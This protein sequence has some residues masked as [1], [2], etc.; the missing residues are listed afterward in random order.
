MQDNKIETDRDTSPFQKSCSS[1][2]SQNEMNTSRTNFKEPL[3]NRNEQNE[4]EV[5]IMKKRLSEKQNNRCGPSHFQR[6][7]LGSVDLANVE[8]KETKLQQYN[9]HMQE[10]QELLN[11]ERLYLSQPAVQ[12]MA[13]KIFKKQLK[14]KLEVQFIYKLMQNL[15]IFEQNTEIM[16]SEIVTRDLVKYFQIS[17]YKKHHKLFDVDQYGD[18]FYIILQGS[19]YCLVPDA[20]KSKAYQKQIN[21]QANDQENGIKTKNQAIIKIVK[22]Q[23][24]RQ[25]RNS[26]T[27]SAMNSIIDLDSSRFDN[28]DEQEQQFIEQN[29]PQ[30]KLAKIMKSGEAFGEIALLSEESKRT[31]TVVFKE[32]SWVL[33]LTKSSFEQIMGN[34]KTNIIQD[35]LEFLKTFEFF[36]SIPNQRLL[37]LLHSMANHQY[38]KK[39]VIY[40]E[41]DP[42]SHIFF[43]KNGSVEI[44]QQ[45]NTFEQGPATSSTT[46]IN[47]KIKIRRKTNSQSIHIAENLKQGRNKNSNGNKSNNSTMIKA[48]NTES[49][50]SESSN[51]L[52]NSIKEREQQIIYFINK[53]KSK[54]QKR[55]AIASL[56]KGSYFGEDEILIHIS[57]KRKSQAVCQSG[58]TEIFSIEKKK[59]FDILKEYGQKQKFIQDAQVR[60]EMRNSRI[61]KMLDNERDQKLYSTSVKYYQKNYEQMEQEKFINLPVH[62]RQQEQSLYYSSK[63]ISTQAISSSQSSIQQIK[64]TLHIPSSTNIPQNSSSN[65][66]GSS[67]QNNVSNNSSNQVF[68]PYRRPSLTFVLDEVEKSEEFQKIYQKKKKIMETKNNVKLFTMKNDQYVF[69]INKILKDGNFNLRNGSLPHFQEK[70]QFQHTDHTKKSGKM[71]KYNIPFNSVLKD[72]QKENNNSILPL[73]S[74]S[75]NITSRYLSPNSNHSKMSFLQQSNNKSTS[76]HMSQLTSPKN[77]KNNYLFL[78]KQ[79]IDSSQIF[80]SLLKTKQQKFEEQFAKSS[81]KNEAGNKNAFKVIITPSQQKQQQQELQQQQPQENNKINIFTKSVYNISSR[82]VQPLLPSSNKHINI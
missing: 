64:S 18:K 69:T 44:S 26:G 67:Y 38:N 10:V 42:S 24:E 53:D 70:F 52:N 8:F 40:T 48:I 72:S 63:N 73:G 56:G 77:N 34:Y 37:G 66:N 11:Q 20:E 80:N 82:L 36:S 74:T 27:I 58:K 51:S 59:L 2:D 60:N 4:N 21:N 5:S 76:V 57:Q 29:Y 9:A 45:Q 68:H 35:N 23:T 25:R 43:I 49:S 7:S 32:D 6:F 47:Q 19:V 79:K 1:L 14:S 41:K 71:N 28:N 15:E 61:N 30:F 33:S 3:S 50:D 39:T 16:S 12:Q 22:S 81:N 55:I 75:P 13:I 54:S 17:F 65:I 78:S 62:N 46:N 31:A